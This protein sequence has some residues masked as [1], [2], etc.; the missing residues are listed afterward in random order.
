MMSAMDESIGKILAALDETKMRNNTLIIFSS[1]N[2]GPAPGRVTDNT[3]LRAGKG[4]VYEGGVHVAACAAWQ[5][6]IPAGST[7]NQ[8][9]HIV[10]LFPT[11]V[12]LAGGKLEQSLPLDGKDAWATISR[13]EA[14]PHAEILLNATPVNGAIRMGDWK[15]VING[16]RVDNEEAA[17]DPAKPAATQRRNRRRAN[18]DASGEEGIE[19]FNLAEDLSE[20]NNLASA[21]PEKVKELRER[22]D[23]L[24]AQ[25]V[26]PKTRPKPADFQS[27]KVW[28]EF[29]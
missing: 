8:P 12:K 18:A 11:L 25:A 27:P 7:V 24:A 17:G 13:G 9:L 28:G 21:H 1:D 2:G 22:Y 6:H 15:L 4:T 16:Q 10:D 20:K 3:P 19:L 5:G 14:S 23:A 29:E 26:P